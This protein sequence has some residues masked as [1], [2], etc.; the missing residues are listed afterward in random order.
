MNKSGRK[1]KDIVKDTGLSI[2]M[3]EEEKMEIRELLKETKGKN[4]AEK[5]I[6]GLR[7]LKVI[8]EDLNK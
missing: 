5:I 2:R 8:Q 7:I 6:K 4:V 1:K 3:T